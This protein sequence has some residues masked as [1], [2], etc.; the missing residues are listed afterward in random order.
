[1]TGP[2]RALCGWAEKL[3]RTPGAMTAADVEALR[4]AGWDDRAIHDACQV[5]GYFNYI[6][7]IVDGLGGDPEPDL[8]AGGDGA[9]S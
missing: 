6:N 2:E 8:P 9:A 1:M 5:V 3:T 7:R 4:R